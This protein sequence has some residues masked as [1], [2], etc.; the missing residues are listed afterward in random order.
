[1]KIYPFLIAFITE[2]ITFANYADQ[3]EYNFHNEP[4]FRHS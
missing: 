3:E 4:Y 2:I 1:M